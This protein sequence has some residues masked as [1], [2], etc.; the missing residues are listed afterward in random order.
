MSAADGMECNI[1]AGFDLR[2]LLLTS[3]HFMEGEEGRISNTNTEGFQQCI[4]VSSFILCEGNFSIMSQYFVV[5]W[6][7]KIEFIFRS[8]LG[9]PF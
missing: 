1:L 4:K 6:F 7:G 9:Q 5:N 3:I 2:S 8:G